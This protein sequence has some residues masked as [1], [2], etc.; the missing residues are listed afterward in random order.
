[1]IGD[2]EMISKILFMCPRNHFQ[3]TLEQC[4]ARKKKLGLWGEYPSLAHGCAT[5]RVPAQKRRE[6]KNNQT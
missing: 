5:C 3:V 6:F 1:M 2:W 4:M